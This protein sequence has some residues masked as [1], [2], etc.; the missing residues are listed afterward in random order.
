MYT[1]CINLMY[2]YMSI[3]TQT[4]TY[5]SSVV[6]DR[7][8]YPATVTSASGFTVTS[9]FNGN[10]Y[11]H[12]TRQSTESMIG[13]QGSGGREQAR[14]ASSHVVPRARVAMPSHSAPQPALLFSGRASLLISG[15]EV[16]M[17]PQF[18]V[19]FSVI[20]VHAVS[21][22]EWCCPEVVLIH[23]QQC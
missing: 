19:D 5:H 9:L 14:Q 6:S 12:N 4:R 18:S 8:R 23:G 7:L 21:Y 16:S 11:T 2:T 15:L 10:A 22:L 17:N 13:Q 1:V 20:H 3:Y